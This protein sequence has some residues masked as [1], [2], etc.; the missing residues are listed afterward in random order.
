MIPL[1]GACDEPPVQV[2]PQPREMFTEWRTILPLRANQRT[3]LAMASGRI[4]YHQPDVDPLS[5]LR[6]LTP[7]GE[8]IDTALSPQRVADLIGITDALPSLRAFDTLAD[9][10]LLAYFSG[11]SRRASMASLV[12]FDPATH[13]L[14]LIASPQQLAVASGMGLLLDLADAQ[15][16]RAGSTIWLRLANVDQTAFLQLDARAVAT[17]E[18]RL[19]RPFRS[20]R[21][22]E[23]TLDVLSTDRFS[24]Q[25]DGMLSMLRPLTGQRWRISLEGQAFVAEAPTTLTHPSVA[26]LFDVGNSPGR[27]TVIHFLPKPDLIP[28]DFSKPSLQSDDTRYPALLYITS[29][30][31]KML[32]RDHLLVRPAFPTHALRIT[33]WLIDP[34]TGDLIA[35]DEMSGEVFRIVRVWK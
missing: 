6:A 35:Y 15:L 31:R 33:A 29:E 3:L 30:E 1:L 12:L 27:E 10:K 5:P 24:G 22:D 26:P 32:D 11:T 9:G 16:V 14:T 19:I 4:Y 18:A 23:T 28:G 17:G 21:V 25:P 8:T 34:G 2:A 7:A 13:A 20:L